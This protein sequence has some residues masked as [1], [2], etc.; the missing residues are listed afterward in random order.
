MLYPCCV[1]CVLGAGAATFID[2]RLDGCDSAPCTLTRGQQVNLAIDFRPK[3]FHWD[4]TVRSALRKEM[5]LE[6][7]Q[8]DYRIPDST[9]EVGV[10]YTFSFPFTVPSGITG[11]SQF[12]LKLYQNF[13]HEICLVLPVN[14]IGRASCRERV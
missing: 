3:Y 4:L 14:E 13:E 1:A 11:Y 6:T 12:R 7:I 8:E 9:V 5:E 2:V 10:L